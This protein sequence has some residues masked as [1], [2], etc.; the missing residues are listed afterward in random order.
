MLHS[1]TRQLVYNIDSQQLVKTL[2]AEQ[3]VININTQQLVWLIDTEKV[4]PTVLLVLID[5]YLYLSTSVDIL[6]PF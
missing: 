3:V 6:L 2:N 5:S 1:N 4:A